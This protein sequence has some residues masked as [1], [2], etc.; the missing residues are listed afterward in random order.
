MLK[1]GKF[2]KQMSREKISKIN[3]HK[4]LNLII[5]FWIIHLNKFVIKK[6]ITTF[7]ILT[8]MNKEKI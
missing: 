6:K 1:S 8:T 2:A 5:M 3:Q 4:F 7:Q